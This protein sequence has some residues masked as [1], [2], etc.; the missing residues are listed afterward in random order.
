MFNTFVDFREVGQY[1]SCTGWL[2]TIR[3]VRTKLLS[4]K[5]DIFISEL[6]FKKQTIMLSYCPD[7][8]LY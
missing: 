3:K 6:S 7:K 2:A 1:D 5:E 8:N 4:L